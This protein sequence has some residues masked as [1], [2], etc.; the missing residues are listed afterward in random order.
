MSPTPVSCGRFHSLKLSVERPPL[1]SFCVS[2]DSGATF[3]YHGHLVRF[4]WQSKHASDA[5]CRVAAA[6]H[7]GSA[8]TGGFVWLRP[9]GTACES[10]KSARTPSAIRTAHLPM[11]RWLP[12][13][14]RRAS[15]AATEP[16]RG[17]GGGRA[18]ARP[19]R[20]P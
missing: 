14:P 18:A 20:P 15:V 12:L 4:E 3:V 19:A 2:H 11:P 8:V 9:Y 7:F 16:R 13:A 5:S 6:S 17:P 10:A 1:T